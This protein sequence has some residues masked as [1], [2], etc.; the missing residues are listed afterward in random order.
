MLNE[1]RKKKVKSYQDRAYKQKEDMHS[2]LAQALEDLKNERSMSHPW[3][4]PVQELE[5]I[6]MRRSGNEHV[7]LSYHKIVTG[8]PHAVAEAEKDSGKFLDEIVSELKKRFKKLSGKPL[9]LKKVSESN[10]TQKYSR[11]F[12]ES[13]P[14][15]GQYG[16]LNTGNYGRF[17]CIYSRVYDLKSPE[18]PY[19]KDE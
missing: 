10:N 12:A 2:C 1:A 13:Q 15:F 16:G 8:L 18:I 5:G 17:Y 19:V 4:K 6:T 11:V 14:L 3:S 7:Q 9:E